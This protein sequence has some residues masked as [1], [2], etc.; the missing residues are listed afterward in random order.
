MKR[1]RDAAGRWIVAGVAA[2]IVAQ[3]FTV[4]IVPT[5]LIF[6]TMIALAV[7][8]NLGKPAS[9]GR[10]LPAPDRLWSAP[11]ARLVSIPVALAFIYLAAR[12]AVADRALALTS[13]NLASGS[14]DS[15]A[16]HY[17]LYER[18][19]PPGTS[20]DLWYSRTALNLA[21]KASNPTVR[22]Q[23]MA[24]AGAAGVRATQNAEDPFDAWYSLAELYASQG[25]SGRTEAC[26]RHA[27]AASPNWFKPHWALAQLLRL[28]SRMQ[29]AEHEAGLAADL[30]GGKNPE[31]ARTLAEIHSERAATVAEHR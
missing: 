6:Y 11:L 22:V 10:N 21:M 29:D 17:A 1:P 3:Q 24:Q 14:P 16:A 25:D 26:L 30:N 31:V 7:A 18:W 27:I 2:G 5:A 15:A 19:R 23:A 28:L 4:F 13:R 9:K 12:F 20:A 8:V